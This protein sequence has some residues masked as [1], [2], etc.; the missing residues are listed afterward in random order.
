M[1]ELFGAVWLIQDVS[2]QADR[3]AE[4][5]HPFPEEATTFAAWLSSASSVD[6]TA[7]A[8]PAGGVVDAV[9]ANVGGGDTTG[10][11]AWRRGSAVTAGVVDDSFSGSDTDK[12]A[13]QFISHISDPGY[14]M[15]VELYR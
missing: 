12:I 1:P 10:A 5:T 3:C 15:Q 14:G 4:P 6:C 13:F 2:E 7:V 8:G 9:G 11:A